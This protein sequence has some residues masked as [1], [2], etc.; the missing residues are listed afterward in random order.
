MCKYYKYIKMNKIILTLILCI[1]SITIYGQKSSDNFSGKWK[2][3]KGVVIEIIKN[4]NI[5]TGIDVELKK[6]AIQNLKFI[7]GKW[8]A[9]VIKPKDG[10]KAIGTFTLEDNKIK[11]VAKKGIFSKT[12]F[13]IKSNY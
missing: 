1:I 2:T 11:I 3:E 8:I 13:L 6:I 9:T 12:V 5:F 10:T 4:G 7:D